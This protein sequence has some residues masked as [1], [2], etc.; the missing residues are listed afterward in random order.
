[1]EAWVGTWT[2]CVEWLSLHETPEGVVVRI[3]LEVAR[4]LIQAH[5]SY[6]LVAA[7]PLGTPTVVLRERA[8]QPWMDH[9]LDA[10]R[11]M[12]RVTVERV[13][14]AHAEPAPNLP[15]PETSWVITPE[16]L[17]ASEVVMFCS[18]CGKSAQ[19]V[20]L[21]QGPAPLLNICE[22]CV[23]V[24]IYALQEMKETR[25]RRRALGWYRGKRP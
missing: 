11:V 9:L 13:A 4:G 20:L 22:E 14:A 6:Q 3:P 25:F 23:D 18:F 12:A 21:V 19:E 2:G 17:D 5:D 24:C 1:M 8:H 16:G 7:A 10:S 15:P